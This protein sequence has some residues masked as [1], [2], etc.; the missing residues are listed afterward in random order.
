MRI[1]KYV[2]KTH[3]KKNEGIYITRIKGT[4]K[5]VVVHKQQ[6]KTPHQNTTYSPQQYTHQKQKIQTAI[7][8]IACIHIIKMVATKGRKK[9][10]K[11]T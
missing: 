9:K 3:R 10:L 2:H 6:N 8:K 7:C 4:Y 1:K 11:Q 5:E